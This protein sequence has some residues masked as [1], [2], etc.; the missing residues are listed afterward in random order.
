MLAEIADLR[1]SKNVDVI[2]KVMDR[3]S[4]CSLSVPCLS[5][6]IHAHHVKSINLTWSST[7]M[8]KSDTG[9]NS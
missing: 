2:C 5:R 4:S 6:C 9:N 3:N 1:V 8:P 7:C